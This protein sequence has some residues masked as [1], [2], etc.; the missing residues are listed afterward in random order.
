M[1]YQPV[2]IR[3]RHVVSELHGDFCLC[4]AV[5]NHIMASE[6]EDDYA[7]ENEA[8]E[9]LVGRGLRGRDVNPQDPQWY[10]ANSGQSFS[11]IL[12]LI[13]IFEIQAC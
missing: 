11:L 1:S 10:L 9:R 12:I 3:C 13:L 5:L 2:K 7:R 6:E 8:G 4:A